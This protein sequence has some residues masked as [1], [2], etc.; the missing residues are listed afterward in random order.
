MSQKRKRDEEEEDKTY[1]PGEEESSD[2]ETEEEEGSSEIQEETS[3]SDDDIHDAQSFLK[4]SKTTSKKTL[5]KQDSSPLKIIKK[6]IVGN[7]QNEEK[8]MNLGKIKRQKMAKTGNEKDVGKTGSDGDKEKDGNKKKSSSIMFNDR[9]ID[10]NLHNEAPQ[11]IKS[12]K[13]KLSGSLILMCHV[14]DGLQSKLPFH[15][16]YPALTFQKKMKDGKAFQFSIPFNL[17]PTLQNAIQ[18]M[19][20]ANPQ[21]FNGIKKFKN[22]QNEI[23]LQG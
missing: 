4:D 13:I 8:N 22:P 16:D 11:N 18:I 15:N 6:K 21:F 19:I 7:V 12:K 23:Q 1:Q 5:P 3:E 17:G 9:N 14:I 10:V 20:D 2:E